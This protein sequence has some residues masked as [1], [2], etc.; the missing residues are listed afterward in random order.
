[1]VGGERSATVDEGPHGARDR[2]P[3]LLD[4]LRGV[5]SNLSA[6]STLLATAIATLSTALERKRET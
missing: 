5:H 1:M 4:T 2:R 6:G 3:V